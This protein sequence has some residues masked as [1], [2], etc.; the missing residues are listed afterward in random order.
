VTNCRLRAGGNSGIFVHDHGAG[1]FSGCDVS[2]HREAEMAVSRNGAPVVRKCALHGGSVGLLLTQ[3]AGG[4]FE[5][6]DVAA[7][8]RA[9]VAIATGSNPTLRRCRIR[10]NGG[11]G[12]WAQDDAA[13]TVVECD[14]RGNRRG[15]WDV[16][17]TCEI[18]VSGN[19]E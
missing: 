3:E 7:N 17:P 12:V 9:G 14:M 18:R 10:S 11:V 6:C 4:D 5:E 19:M 13:A 16:D 2:G 15:A 8:S 1:T